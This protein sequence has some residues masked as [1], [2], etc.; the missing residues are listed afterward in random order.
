[1]LVDEVVEPGDDPRLAVVEP[2]QIGVGLGVDVDQRGLRN[3]P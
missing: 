1:V 2:S 3:T